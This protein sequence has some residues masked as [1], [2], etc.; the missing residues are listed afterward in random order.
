MNV[1]SPIG[2]LTSDHAKFALAEL[3]LSPKIPYW[4]AVIMVLIMPVT[5]KAAPQ[6]PKFLFD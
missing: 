6:P 2:K 4:I 1:K 5:V 3:E